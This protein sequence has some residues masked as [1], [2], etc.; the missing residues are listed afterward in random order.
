[1][2]KPTWKYRHYQEIKRGQAARK[3]AKCKARTK[4]SR[5]RRLDRKYRGRPL[6][7]NKRASVHLPQEI[8]LYFSTNHAKLT[9]CLSKIRRL[10][11]LKRPVVMV[12]SN[13][14]RITAA[15]GLLMFS[16][17]SR[18]ILA[19]GQHCIK[20]TRP[21]KGP[22]FNDENAVEATLNQI[23]FY[24]T[25]G[26][27]ERDIPKPETVSC[28]NVSEGILTEGEIAGNMIANIVNSKIPQT[29]GRDL[30]RGS[31]EAVANCVEHAYSDD[32]FRRDNLNIDDRR[33]WMFVGIREQ[34]LVVLICDLGMGIPN[35]IQKTQSRS[36]LDRIFKSFHFLAQTE[37][38][39]IKTATL[40]RRTKT[41]LS[42]R[43]KGG[44]DARTLVEKNKF[45]LLSIYSNKG[46]YKLINQGT[47]SNEKLK[48]SALD[49][50]NSILG[51]I[52]EWSIFTG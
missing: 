16:E 21:L 51:T 50:K 45:S 52:V 22:D 7:W 31:V 44:D 23:G 47:C 2:I 15:G 18:L 27:S 35:T 49:Q 40:V 46:C 36:V 41:A 13:T 42:Y 20:A 33:W 48:E 43:G 30:Y 11:A 39:W 8:D 25:L 26:Q 19:Y 37:S 6:S 4:K 9:A 5:K 24:R 3:I 34:N 17:V 32:S 38:D 1:M 28:W 10:V 12:F 14:K 29:I